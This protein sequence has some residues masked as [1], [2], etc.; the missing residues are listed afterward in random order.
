MASFRYRAVTAAG[1]ITTGVLDADSESDA[2]AQIRGLGHLPIAATLAGRRWRALL[3][4]F[5]ARRASANTISIATQELAAL[6]GARLPLDRALA[7][8]AELEETRRLRPTLLAVLASVR[9][10]ASLAD[11]LAAT[12]EFPKYYVTTVRA[13]EHGGNLEATLS[14]LADYL[15]RASA[16]RETVASAM[17]Y[18]A[19]LLVTAGFSVVMILVFVLPQ[20][21]PLFAQAGKALPTS[22]RI[23]LDIGDFLTS[24]WWALGIV[25]GLIY[26][27]FKRLAKSPSFLKALRA[28]RARH[29][30]SRAQD[31]DRTLQPHAGHLAAERRGAAACPAHRARHAD[32][33]HRDGRRG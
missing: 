30:R 24:Y 7:L 6:L 2:I 23:V 29:R 16:V 1:A 32:Q 27:L 14:R 33:F 28:A 12:G 20:F 17:V 18:P 19:I 10:G 26:L 15:T 25:I 21:A 3:P 11:A 8:L 4:V 13:G 9:D 31:A 22:T 5:P